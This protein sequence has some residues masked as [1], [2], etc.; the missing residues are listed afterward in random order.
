MEQ[1]LAADLALANR[2]IA[3]LR[4]RLDTIESDDR[5]GSLPKTML[6]DHSFLKRALAVL[7]HYVAATVIIAIPCYLV[8]FLI[9]V[10]RAGFE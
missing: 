1:Q 9:M 6:L 10:A 5:Y 3:L 7:G 4:Q 2:E 8:V